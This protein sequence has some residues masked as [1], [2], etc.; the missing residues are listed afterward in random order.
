MGS[1]KEDNQVKKHYKNAS[2]RM[3]E[4]RTQEESEDDSQN[5]R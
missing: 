5:E 1:A 2:H 3:K 4:G